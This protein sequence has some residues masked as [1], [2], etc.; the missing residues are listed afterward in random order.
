[1]TSEEIW[2][3]KSDEELLE[4]S[5][6]LDEYT[7]EGQRVILA[8]LQHRRQTGRMDD[9]ILPGVEG[10]DAATGGTPAD[11]PSERGNLLVRL[12]R[13]QIPLATT[14]WGYG[15]VGHIVCAVLLVEAREM[16]PTLA[17][18]LV[19]VVVLAYF[20]LMLFDLAQRRSI[21]RGRGVGRAG[22]DLGRGLGGED[23]GALSGGRCRF[24]LMSLGWPQRPPRQ[25]SREGAVKRGRN[26]QPRVPAT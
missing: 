9:V 12:W 20:V 3:R 14:Y 7:V 18:A 24:F 25:C 10:T 19:A 21:H 17:A 26:R 1:M 2:Q 4:A 22:Q 23:R 13:G 8:E 6:R 5:T 11:V 15:V 16:L